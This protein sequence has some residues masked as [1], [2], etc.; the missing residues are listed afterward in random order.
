MPEGPLTRDSPLI[1]RFSIFEFD[2]AT[3]ELWKAGRRIRL[4]EQACQVLRVLIERPGTLVTRDEL[5]KMLW[6]EDTFVDFDTGLNVVINKIRQALDD[7]AS[8]PRFV[9]TLPRR[10]YRFIAPV[11]SGSVAAATIPAE[12]VGTQPGTSRS[13]R[14][15]AMASVLIVGVTAALLWSNRTADRSSPGDTIQALAVIPFENLSADD[16]QR[17]LVDGITEALTTELASIHALRVVPRQSTKHY[18]GTAKSI[19]EIGRELKV[20]AVVQGSMLLSEDRIRLT[21]QLIDVAG[22]RYRWTQTYEGSTRDIVRLQGEAVAAIARNILVAMTP[23]ERARLAAARVVDPAAY[24]AYFAAVITWQGS[25]KPKH[26]RRGRCP[27]SSARSRSTPHTRRPMLESRKRNNCVRPFSK[28]CHP[29]KS[30]GRQ[31]EPRGK[32]SRWTRTCQRHM[33]FWRAF[34]CRSSTGQELKQVFGGLSILEPATRQRSSGTRISFSFRTASTRLS[35]LPVK[36]NRWILWIS[37]LASELRSFTIWREVRPGHQE[38]RRG[39][40]AR[41]RPRYR[42]MVS[43]FG[44]RECQTLRRRSG[45][46]EKGRRAA[47]ASAVDAR[48]AC[49]GQRQRRSPGGWLSGDGRAEHHLAPPIRLSRSLR[50]RV[51]PASRFQSS[52]RM[53]RTCVSGANEPAA[54]SVLRSSSRSA[55]RRP[56]LRR[57][58]QE[59]EPAARTSRMIRA[60]LL[61]SRRRRY[62]PVE[63]VV[64]DELTVMFAVVTDEGGEA[65][66]DFQRRCVRLL[67][68]LRAASATEC[69]TAAT[70]FA[71]VAYSVFDSLVR[72]RVHFFAP[73]TPGGIGVP[74]RDV[75]QETS[76][77]VRTPSTGLKLSLLFRKPFGQLDHIAA[78]VVPVGEQHLRSS[79]AVWA[80]PQLARGERRKHRGCD[81]NDDGSEF[82]LSIRESPSVSSLPTHTG[83]YPAAIMCPRTRSNRHD[84]SGSWR[85]YFFVVALAWGSA[86]ANGVGADRGANTTANTWC[87]RIMPWWQMIQRSLHL[88]CGGRCPRT[89]GHS[90]QRDGA[91]K[92]GADVRRTGQAR[93]LRELRVLQGDREEDAAGGM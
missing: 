88:S 43:Q 29:R 32:H 66:G 56:A 12:P 78:D 26:R 70:I 45:D 18:R 72:R 13:V 46:V 11:T 71:L 1:V 31:S 42:A 5:C 3:G 16:S 47:R 87:Q 7:S 51:H 84:P 33:P 22:D 90:R 10:G 59:S 44:I 27:S 14:W 64:D 67:R 20:D 4:Q 48:S 28:V 35:R 9:E 92:G 85:W 89:N 53:A 75:A 25:L 61:T 41:S 49:H 58:C 19:G 82:S 93:G 73:S 6:P 30:G 8:T 38:V 69:F 2:T 68:Q 17:Y 81:S 23:P 63:A 50:G 91:F 21:V 34:S 65:V 37:T 40:D 39:L 36:P 52:I 24:D 57:A 55:S 15:L 76:A 79:P 60:R 62:E 80:A 86:P 74:E 83:R 54:L 77:K